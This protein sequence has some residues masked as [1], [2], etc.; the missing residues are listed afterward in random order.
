MFEMNRKVAVSDVGAD[1]AMTVTAVTQFMQDCECFQLDSEPT[2]S[3]FF[4]RSCCGMYLASRQTD[5]ARLPVYGEEVTVKTWVLKCNRVFGERNTVIYDKE[6]EPLIKSF[7]IGAFCNLATGK[8]VSVDMDII[9]TVPFEP[10]C[11]MEHLPRKIRLPED[12]GE[13]REPFV[14]ADRHIDYFGHMNNAK[15]IEE[16]WG[17]TAGGMPKRVRVEYAVP[18]KK[19]ESLC[20]KVFEEVGCTTVLLAGENGSRHS[21]VSFICR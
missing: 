20:P 7:A 16:A 8:P 17:Q 9:G 10:P 14:V 5:I 4:K 18:T 2:L 19:G 13:E 1:A 11:E 6:G 3:A 21:V 15:Y 12:G